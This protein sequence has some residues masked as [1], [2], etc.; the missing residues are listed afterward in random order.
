VKVFNSALNDAQVDSYAKRFQEE[1]ALSSPA[2]SASTVSPT[3]APTVSPIDAPTVSRTDGPTVSPIDAPTVSRTDAPTVS[4]T[5]APTMSP[6]P[7][8][9]PTALQLIQPHV[10]IDF[11]QDS[12]SNTNYILHEGAQ[13]QGPAPIGISKALRIDRDGPYATIPNVN[14][15]PSAMP[16][17][18]LMI[19][20]Y[21][22]SIANKRGWVFG[23]EMSGYDRTILI[24]DERFGG[25]V[26]SALGYNWNP[27]SSSQG[28]APT[29]EWVHVTAVFRQ[30]GDSYVFLNGI[31]SENTSIGDNS[32]G[33][34]EL[35]IGRASWGGHWVDSWIKEVKVF[36]SALNDAQVDSY[37]KRFQEEIALS[38]PAPSSSM[39]NASPSSAQIGIPSLMPISD[40]TLPCYDALLPI[41]HDGLELSC[42]LIDSFGACRVDV[43]QSHCPITCNACPEYGCVDTQA[44][45]IANRDT[46]TCRDLRKLPDARLDDF[47]SVPV[48]YSTCRGLCN[49][50]NV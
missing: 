48:V 46:Y 45:F 25:G 18:T 23:H 35:W 7:S 49:I 15:G 29:K 8:V 31:R 41:P 40:S 38:S 12:L 28:N 19:G 30:G 11:S 1:I 20:L 14:I 39:L 43:A 13:I 5:D 24:H 9:S 33:L 2:P 34:G 6:G 27:W 3:D 10:Q 26:A 44:P 4:P 21:L 47:C 22:E 36:N 17:C 32:E 42:E 50:Y 37:A 16:E